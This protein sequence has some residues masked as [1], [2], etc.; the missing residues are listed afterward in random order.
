MRSATIILCLAA[1]AGCS[2]A[3]SGPQ[4]PLAQPQPMT[5]PSITNT[6]TA[7]TLDVTTG[8]G[9]Y[10]RSS[11][12][13]FVKLVGVTDR[14]TDKQ[15]VFVEWGETYTARDWRSYYKAASDSAQPYEF[16][17]VSRSGPQCDA[18]QACTFTEKYRISIPPREMLIAA[19]EG[20]S[21]KVYSRRGDTRTVTV[22]PEI[23]AAF[24]DRMAEAARLAGR[25]HGDT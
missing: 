11:G 5:A 12:T 13:E 2:A 20:L 14:V 10:P 8:D 19:R 1:L 24:N 4:T 25:G 21:F 16:V 17:Q 3:S 7:A 18:A 23:A 15:Q 6:A 9:V 22:S